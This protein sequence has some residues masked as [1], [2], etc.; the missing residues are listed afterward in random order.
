MELDN[1]GE[2][3][4]AAAGV[5]VCVDG[6]VGEEAEADLVAEGHQGVVVGIGGAS[7]HV[8]A[9]DSCACG[10]SA[11]SASAAEEIEHLFQSAG[12]EGGVGQSP[13]TAAFE[14]DA[15]GGGKGCDEV[16]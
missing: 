5:D 12:V 11:D 14:P 3:V 10:A 4:L 8:G 2:V 15:G 7:H 13:V 9:L 1:G 6:D 16:S